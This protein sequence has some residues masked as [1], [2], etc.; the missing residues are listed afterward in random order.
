M[1]ATF[2]NVLIDDRFIEEWVSFGLAQMT[3]YLVK[4]AKFAEYCKRRDSARRPA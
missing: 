4:H 1:D 3:D 2:S